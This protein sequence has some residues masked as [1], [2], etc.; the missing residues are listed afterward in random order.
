[1]L[2]KDRP[3]IR[4]FIS[5]TFRDMHAERDYLNRFV[6]PELRNRCHLRGTE[7][8]GV[9]L[10]WGITPEEARK[11]GT[12]KT[13]LEEMERCK[14]FFVCLMGERYGWT[15]AP[16]EVPQPIFEAVLRSGSLT[17]QEEALLNNFY[18]IDT[19]V[20]PPAYRLGIKDQEII[21]L[22]N[23]A[24]V[25]LW[26]LHDES[27]TLKAGYSIT[28]REI[29]KAIFD[30]QH[31]MARAFFY[32]RSQSG[33]GINDH[34]HFPASFIPSFLETEERN[35]SK[36]ALLKERIREKSGEVVVREYKAE[37]AGIQLDPT[38]LPPDLSSEDRFALQNGFVRPEEWLGLSNELRAALLESGTVALN[39]MEGVGAQL[40]DD[41]WAGIEAEIEAI[42]GLRTAREAGP[43]PLGHH[44]RFILNHTRIFVGRAELMKRMLQYAQGSEGNSPFVVTGAAGVGKSALLSKFT[45]G[46]RSQ[47]SASVV[48]PYFV[49]SA[50]GSEQLAA[51]LR[52]LCESLRDAGGFDVELPSDAD[53]L[54]RLFPSLLREAAKQKRVLIIL[55]ALNQL[56]PAAHSHELLW[57]PFTVP[58]GVRV[59]VS[60]QQGECLDRLTAR[61]APDHIVEVPELPTDDRRRLIKETL[62]LRGK[63]LSDEHI[64]ELLDLRL[65]PDA[66]LPLYLLVALEELSLFGSYEALGRRIS[67]LAP[68]LTE[69]FQQVLARLEQAYDEELVRPVLRWIAISRS[70][71]SE[72]EVINLLRAYKP[73]IQMAHWL[74]LYRSVQFYLRP[75]E[76][77]G[78]SKTN[79]G[80]IAFFY[81][82]FGLAVFE[83]YF[84]MR[85][86]SADP[87]EGYRHAHSE[88]ADYF[89]SVGHDHGD[90]G[91]WLSKQPRALSEVPYHLTQSGRWREL[92]E[93]LTDLS[94]LEAKAE[95]DMAFELA[96]NLSDAAEL[97]LD[98][99][100]GE[101]LAAL[102][103]ALRDDI[104]FIIRHPETIFQCLWN[105]CWWHDAPQARSYFEPCD[106]AVTQTTASGS[107]LFERLE[108][109]RAEKERRT[110]GFRWVRSLRPLSQ[111]SIDDQQLVLRGH[112][113]V[114]FD[115]AFSP[116][117]GL[118]ASG[119]RDGAVI[120]WDA[121][122]GEERA[123][124]IGHRNQVQ[125]VTFSRDGAYV[126]SGSGNPEL[127]TSDGKLIGE[128]DYTVRVWNIAD[129]T[130][131]ARLEGHQAMVHCVAVSPDGQ[132]VAS[133][134][135][136]G[137]IRMWDIHGGLGLGSFN[138]GGKSVR[139]LEFSPNGTVLFSAS[140]DGTI[141]VW[142][143]E[144][145]KELKRLAL[146]KMDLWG[147]SVSPDGTRVAATETR[148]G[149]TIIDWQS[150]QEIS[151]LPV[152]AIYDVAWSADGRQIIGACGDGTVRI[153]DVGAGKEIVTYR[154]HEGPV[155]S[156]ASSP[157]GR[158]FAS[159]SMDGSVRV[160]ALS[161]GKSP[162]RTQGHERT[163]LCLSYSPDGRYFATGSEDNT[164]CLWN[165]VDGGLL[166]RLIGHT[167]PVTC[168]AFLDGGRQLVS[169]SYDDS[170][171]LWETATAR[172][173]AELPGKTLMPKS[174]GVSPDGRRFAY[175]GLDSAIKVVDVS[176]GR[177][178][179]SLRCEDSQSVLAISPDG[180]Y[181]AAADI[182]GTVKLWNLQTGA[183][184][185]S[186]TEAGNGITCLALSPIERRLACGSLGEVKVWDWDRRVFHELKGH[187]HLVSGVAFS[188]DGLFLVS[189]A[190]DGTARVWSVASGLCVGVING[191]VDARSIACGDPWT[192]TVHA[193]YEI[194][195]TSAYDGSVV[196]WFPAMP[197]SLTTLADRRTWAGA[198]RTGQV[199]AFR[200]EGEEGRPNSILDQVPRL[201][202][203][204]DQVAR[205][206]LR[207]GDS[208]QANSLLDLRERICREFGDERGISECESLK[209]VI[210]Q[211]GASR[212]E[213]DLSRA[214]SECVQS[215]LNQEYAQA[216]KQASALAEKM[217]LDHALLQ[218]LFISIQRI[219][220]NDRKVS[221]EWVEKFAPGFM[222]PIIDRWHRE[223]L[224]TTLGKKDDMSEL[225]RLAQTKE[226]G[227]QAYYYIGARLMNDIRLEEAMRAF[228]M[229]LATNAE[230]V[231]Y[232]FAQADAQLVS[233]IL[234]RG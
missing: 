124:L 34:P 35:R 195:F 163:I 15:P 183:E 136:E 132:C 197:G 114:V 25:R 82:Q 26:E 138:A 121:S 139:R 191:G 141:R 11:R 98:G 184:L 212:E 42:R 108:S 100:T 216:V 16:E 62:S 46:C 113:H 198:N 45:E 227:C 52:W 151:R 180:N 27:Q 4:V 172:R 6:F 14:P 166:A 125:S 135:S 112:S 66:G 24:L 222:E 161:T 118:I 217:Y 104:H 176:A 119:S 80:Q 131:A 13:C 220:L 126:I 117:G 47:L 18:S 148:T 7:F 169:G 142:Q 83:R 145:G 65:R 59:V 67:L 122:S 231:E 86:F 101:H 76:E 2:S 38:L 12:L 75:M 127:K 77:E 192:V 53:E 194:A 103:I 73:H 140:F 32:L 43:Q 185:D 224:M 33:N 70:G 57:F 79:G 29:Q 162:S 89:I 196:G 208:E 91:V 204:W 219:M 226:Q 200:L 210:T 207:Q 63:R 186:L 160:W 49:G 99:S 22:V 218:V 115:V 234:T 187:G 60:T 5:S 116:D 110:P 40:L 181:L 92:E 164:V 44:E 56:D 55:D 174:I 120:V 233:H 107:K 19:T 123:R 10:R 215:F 152:P 85:S 50:P 3:T 64:D 41:L 178:L 93:T 109:W 206:A 36:L 61:V 171:L 213:N 173:I 87:T 167:E 106:T 90:A 94:F 179:F 97:S 30:K 74:R 51:L 143:P 95:A 154:G 214:A 31:C 156:V 168:V 229:S 137:V 78:T 72:P 17:P 211:S 205:E 1:M 150:G 8:V 129:E 9:D 84:H 199:Y 209:A 81:E 225:L 146:T 88:L 20:I 221:K 153:W 54:R 203:T 157:N 28:A 111:A 175:S 190:E 37:Y 105:R 147:M 130:E 68:E 71:L 102:A 96:A 223:L 58:P 39:G 201:S 182:F 232:L 158:L 23:E 188:T 149:I 230:C 144:T 155:M 133:A 189:E 134:D 48:L 128:A 69:L 193:S 21:A 165:A 177:E 202:L 228:E 159:G 170:L